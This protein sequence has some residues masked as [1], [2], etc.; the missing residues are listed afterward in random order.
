MTKPPSIKEIA[1]SICPPPTT[2]TG[3]KG[4]ARIHH[5]D[6]DWLKEIT[7]IEALLSEMTATIKESYQARIEELEDELATMRVHGRTLVHIIKDDLDYRPDDV[8]GDELQ[9]ASAPF[10]KIAYSKPAFDSEEDANEAALERTF[11]KPSGTV[12]APATED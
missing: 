11:C 2:K 5:D 3:R 7:R 10:E 1:E 8:A 4:C 12:Y 9:E 6:P